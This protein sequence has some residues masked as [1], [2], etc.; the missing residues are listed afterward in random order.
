MSYNSLGSAYSE[1]DFLT[2]IPPKLQN[3]N[4][5]GSIYG[6]P[7]VKFKQNSPSDGITYYRNYYKDN[8]Y[9]YSATNQSDLNPYLKLIRDFEKFPSMR[10]SASD[11]TY[12]SDLGVYPTNRMWTLRRFNDFVTVENNL[13]K[14]PNV[15]PISTVVGWI[16]PTEESFFSFSFNEKWTTMNDRLD[17]V[18]MKIL[19]EEFGFKAENVISLPGW[20]QG[21]LF[22]FLQAMGLASDEFDLTHIPQGD[23]AVLS[24]AATRAKDN[25][26]EYGQES[27]MSLT[28]NTSYEQKFVGDIDPGAAFLDILDNLTKM[29]TRDTKYVFSGTSPIIESLRKAN[30][31]GGTLEDWWNFITDVLS[32]FLTAIEKI[33]TEIKGAFSNP[34]IKVNTENTDPVNESAVNA[35]TSLVG[36]VKNITNEFLQSV[37]ASTVAKWRYALDGSIGLM[38]GQS[39]TPW[40]I[41]LGNPLSPT[42]SLSNVKITQISVKLKNEMAFNDMPTKLDVEIQL[43]L[44]RNLGAQEIFNMFN[45]GY[46]R[47]YSSSKSVSYTGNMKRRE[48]DEKNKM[49]QQSVDR[50]INKQRANEQV[51]A[52]GGKPIE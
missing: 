20:S 15:S 32:A 43:A 45:N 37:L 40:H 39:T 31:N 23:P 13:Q 24:E 1:L 30:A 21:L 16:N 22:G 47:S 10:F 33:F 42:V 8:V 49:S 50:E 11:F 41:T 52:A 3:N 25:K 4:N 36:G 18:M 46:Q 2:I 6:D 19:Q 5:K 26:P 51:E 7:S 14:M 9:K 38:T 17:Q 28:L 27:T 48:F 29:G 12:L 35:V 34:K 44:G